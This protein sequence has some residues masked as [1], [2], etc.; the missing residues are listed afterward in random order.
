MT[1]LERSLIIQ[2]LE[3]D[4][5]RGDP[6]TAAT[7]DSSIEGK[8]YFLAKASGVLAGIDIAKEVFVL[9]AAQSHRENLVRFRSVGKE[10]SHVSAGEPL[11][12]IYAP[13]DAILTAERVAL[14]LLQRMSGIATLTR[15]YV[16]RVQGTNAK[17]L[18]TR[19]TAPL[20]RP[21]D[22]YG[23]LCGGGT[24]N[25]Y[26]LAEMILVKDNHVA[27]NGMDIRQV[28][29][30]LKKYFEADAHPLIPV[31][32]EV[33]SLEQFRII[34]DHGGNIVSRVMFDN[35]EIGKLREGMAMNAG[36]FE[37]EASGGVNL[38][39]VRA[40]AETGVDYISVGAL[41]HSVT[42]LDISLEIDHVP[43]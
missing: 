14:N 1:S 20:L 42:G 3:E 10:G 41:T 35:F 24:N 29:D 27:A 28:L 21:F 26:S 22:R 23:V 16:K 19:K 6:T 5:G 40:I 4:T 30:K 37:T 2:A 36:T 18:D 13:L 31:E 33:T 9:F 7:I 25:R 15:E 34:L 17:I 43:V 32:I 39:S 12:E 8:A 11:D 38:H